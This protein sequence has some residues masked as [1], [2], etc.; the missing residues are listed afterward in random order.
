MNVRSRETGHFGAS[1][2]LTLIR[3]V[4]KNISPGWTCLFLPRSF[5]VQGCGRPSIA[6]AGLCLRK[7]NCHWMV[8]VVGA[9]RLQ[10]NTR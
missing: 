10:G 2:A 1:S 4:R 6:A 3:H 5:W 7:P 9:W 8:R